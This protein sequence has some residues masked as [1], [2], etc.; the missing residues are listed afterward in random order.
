M[1]TRAIEYAG[2]GGDAVT[3]LV[4]EPDGSG[5]RPGPGVLFVHWGFGDRA[6]FAREASIH[7]QAGVTSLLIDAPGFGRRAGPR[8]PARSPDATAAYAGRLLGDLRSGLDWLAARNQVDPSRL[9]YVGHSLG[10]AIGA[11]FLAREPRVKAGVLMT[12]VGRLSRVWVQSPSADRQRLVEFDG[13]ENLPRVDARLLLQFALRDEW[14]GRSDAERQIAVAKGDVEVRWYAS[15]H[16]LAGEAASD[17]ASW[18]AR[19]LEYPSVPAVPVGRL[20]PRGQV[21]RYRVVASIMR[22]A[23][24]FGFGAGATNL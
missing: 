3:A 11:C 14:V 16:A 2:E 20:L 15:D 10:A 19:Q 24:F 12:P 17:R 22:A 23:R 6:S 1:A 9:G 8:V 13:L 5:S 21:I 7:A 4:V 18:L